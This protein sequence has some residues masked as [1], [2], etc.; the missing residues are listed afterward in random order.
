MVC[1]DNVDNLNKTLEAAKCQNELSF[2]E[3]KC[4]I[5][6][7]DN[8]GESTTTAIENKEKFM[9]FLCLSQKGG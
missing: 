5:G 9:T 4:S 8:L 2:I 1:V 6:S 7:R 3:V